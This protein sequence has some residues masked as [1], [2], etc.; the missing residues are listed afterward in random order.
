MKPKRRTF[1]FGAGSMIEWNGPKTGEL[2]DIILKTGFKTNNGN[3]IT[4]FI[5]D[6]LH[7]KGFRDVSF[8]TIISVIEEFIVFYSNF[9][10]DNNIPSTISCFFNAKFEDELLNF[11]VKGGIRKHGYVLEIPKGVSNDFSKISL[12]NENP[13]QYFF[14]HLIGEILTNV[15]ARVIDYSYFSQ[16]HSKVHLD[17][18]HSK[19]FVEWMKL[20]LNQTPL[21]LYT[22]NYDNVFKVLLEQNAIP[23]FDGFDTSI[24]ID[25]HANIRPQVAKILNDFNVNVHYNLHGSVNWDVEQLDFHELPNPEIFYRHYPNLPINN[26]PSSIQIEKGR[27]L[28]LTNIISGYQKA[29]KSMIT[30]FKQMQSSFDKDCCL[31]DEIYV[32]GYSFGDEHINSSLRTAIRHN[33]GLKILIVDPFFRKN[34]FDVEVAMKLFSAREKRNIV[35]R[36]IEE[37]IYSFVDDTFIVYTMTF[38]EFRERQLSLYNIAAGGIHDY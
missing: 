27:T 14:E 29:Q 12:Y 10:S 26:A 30:P 3:T 21:R 18:L 37:N 17:A 19:A 7:D 5:Y 38:S 13:E 35:P 2:T 28:M 11:S 8:E 20:H 24:F 25:F 32:I 9:N 15:S 22:L 6:T 1:L 16:N 34:D 33:G 31:C 36:K 4:Q 23:I